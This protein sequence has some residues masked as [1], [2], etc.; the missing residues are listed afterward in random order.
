MCFQKLDFRWVL[1]VAGLFFNFSLASPI[2]AAT[3]DRVVAKINS[4]VITMSTLEN[5]AEAYLSQMR[6]SANN[7][8]QLSKKDLMKTV[9]DS[10]FKGYIGIEF[11]GHGTDPIK[12]ILATKRLIERAVKEA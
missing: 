11:E 1:L 3:Y 7:E 8:K 9:L 12:G 6:N 5:R 10:G 4:D 2:F